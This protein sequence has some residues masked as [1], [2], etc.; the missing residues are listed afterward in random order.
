MV[1][2]WLKMVIPPLEERTAH[3]WRGAEKIG[4]HPV[5]SIKIPHEAKVRLRFEIPQWNGGATKVTGE[6]PELILQ[7]EIEV[8]T[9]DGLHQFAVAVRKTL[10]I[11]S[12]HTTRVGFTVVGDWDTFLTVQDARHAVYPKF[13]IADIQVSEAVQLVKKTEQ[14]LDIFGDRCD[15]LEQ[16]F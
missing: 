9:R 10:P 15:K 14:R 1:A 7:G 3:G 16:R 13:F 5:V 11:D 12:F 6:M 8:N 4:D 2:E